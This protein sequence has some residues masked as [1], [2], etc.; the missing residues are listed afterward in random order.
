[1]IQVY[2]SD[3]HRGYE[4]AIEDFRQADAWAQENCASYAGHDVVDVSDFSMNY[5]TVAEYNFAQ[6][7]DALIFKLRWR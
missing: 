3:E 4:Q 2:L 7:S 6:E 1:M 5:D